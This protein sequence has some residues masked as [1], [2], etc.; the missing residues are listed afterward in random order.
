MLVWPS[1]LKVI[2]HHKISFPVACFSRHS[3]PITSI[4]LAETERW[5]MTYLITVKAAGNTYCY[6]VPNKLHMY[7]RLLT[8]PFLWMPYAPQF[9]LRHGISLLCL[10][11]DR[12]QRKCFFPAACIVFSDHSPLG[13]SSRCHDSVQRRVRTESELSRWKNISQICSRHLTREQD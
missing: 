1:S 2:R 5:S 7:Q 9:S 13:P 3:R 4:R 8:S 11:M 10:C 12:R 6:W